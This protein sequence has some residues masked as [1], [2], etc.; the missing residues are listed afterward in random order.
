M[1]EKEKQKSPLM[2][3]CDGSIIVR[4]NNDNYDVMSMYEED[5]DNKMDDYIANLNFDMYN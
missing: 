5:S 4:A 1:N 3:H 2:T